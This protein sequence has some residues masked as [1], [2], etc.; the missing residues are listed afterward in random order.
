M[1]VPPRSIFM[2][3][4]SHF[5]LS[6]QVKGVEDWSNLCRKPL[7][8][9]CSLRSSIRLVPSNLGTIHN[10]LEVIYFPVLSRGICTFFKT[11]NS[12]FFFLTFL[13]H[14]MDGSHYAKQ[15]FLDHIT[16]FV[17]KFIRFLLHVFRFSTDFSLTFMNKMSRV[18]ICSVVH[19]PV[20][21]LSNELILVVNFARCKM[22]GVRSLWWNPK[23]DPDDS[24]LMAPFDLMSCP[25]GHLID[26]TLRFT[27][28][29]QKWDKGSKLENARDCHIN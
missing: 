14:E 26:Q 9:A 19:F 3:K 10:L 5:V 21:H 29:G 13:K 1:V 18:F 22:Q 16:A 8:F 24:W 27:K 15:P 4:D 25:C 6:V 28:Q 20:L 2:R 7:T 17:F 12:V 23:P 11:F